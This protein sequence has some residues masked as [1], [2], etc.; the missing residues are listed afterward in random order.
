MFANVAKLGFVL[1]AVVVWRSFEEP[2]QAQPVR[3]R[4]MTYYPDRREW[5]EEA[6]PPPGTPEGDLHV[7]RQEIKAKR[8]RQALSGLKRFSKSYETNN[9]VYPPA[10]LAKV[11]ALIGRRAFDKA[12]LELQSFL[13]EFGGSQWTAEALR[14]KHVIAETFL[15]GYKRRLFGLRVLSSK[16]LGYACLD[17]IATDHPDLRIAELAIKTRADSFFEESEHALAEFEYARLNREYPNSRYGQ[18]A[19]RRSAE[20]ALASFGGV[21]YDRASLLEAEERYREYQLRYPSASR[22][23]GVPLILDSIEETKAAKEYAIGHY[24]E[25]TDHLSSA[26]YYYQLVRRDWPE[27]VAARKAEQSLSLLGV[28]FSSVR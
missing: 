6:P 10:T 20:S 19:W 14:L 5:T 13:A 17:E 9:G 27:S 8:F 22:R 1:S 16:E 23:D 3:A 15:S 28:S 11:E 18:V 4:T 7:I 26:V 25:R 12:Y 2:I 24:Y 21:P